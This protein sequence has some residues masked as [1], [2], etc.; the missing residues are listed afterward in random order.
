M[1]TE[2]PD[3]YLE[4]NDT[5]TG[6]KFI[7]LAKTSDVTKDGRDDMSTIVGIY[8][9]DDSIEDDNGEDFIN[10][11]GTLVETNVRNAP[12]LSHLERTLQMD[13]LLVAEEKILACIDT[14]GD[15]GDVEGGSGSKAG[16]SSDNDELADYAAQVALSDT[17]GDTNT[18]VVQLPFVDQPHVDS[19]DKIDE[20]DVTTD[21]V[22]SDMEH[23]YHVHDNRRNGRN[24]HDDGMTFSPIRKN[25]RPSK[26]NDM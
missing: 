21:K 26:Y 2:D 24:N 19:G 11:I 14:S 10:K 1:I 3:M 4:Y 13:K 22:E 15:E 25:N 7:P 12:N 16:Q 5:F 8:Y 23:D 9:I 6:M 20:D 18:N 17:N